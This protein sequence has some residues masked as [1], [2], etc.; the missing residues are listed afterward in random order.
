MASNRNE[1]IKSIEKK[2]MK[3]EL[4]DVSYVFISS[5]AQTGLNELKDKIWELLI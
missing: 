4:P 3:S 2:H 5:V 1:K